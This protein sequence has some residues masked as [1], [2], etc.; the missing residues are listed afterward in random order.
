[1]HSNAY[2]YRFIV[3]I[4]GLAAMLLSLAAT[5]L[6]DRQD[7]NR[8]L[9][10]KKNI[11]KS[12]NLFEKGMTASDIESSF[13]T[14]IRKKYVTEKGEY[15]EDI[16]EL[17]LFVYERD[18][19]IEGYIIPVSGKGLWSTINGFLAL[20]L[21]KNTVIGLTFYEHGETPGLGGEIEKEWFTSQF[22]GKK[23][24]ESDLIMGGVN[25]VLKSITIAKGEALIKDDF[26]VDGI[27]GATLTTKGV[28]EFL[29]RDLKK[30]EDFLKI[31][32][33]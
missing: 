29:L 15:T 14:N 11:L 10:T 22:V 4:T 32:D 25:V 3:L 13:N 27:S 30:Y 6:K 21:N 33:C 23:I 24:F 20:E 1:M 31:M 17:P 9:D 8:A 18:S 2:T 12:V 26:N 5:G 28:N 16:N 19:M 7:F